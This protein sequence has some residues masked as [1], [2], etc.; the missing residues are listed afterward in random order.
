MCWAHKGSDGEGWNLRYIRTR[1]EP[2]VGYEGGEGLGQPMGSWGSWRWLGRTHWGQPAKL[3]PFY[4][5]KGSRVTVS[6]WGGAGVV[7]KCFGG[8]G[9]RSSLI[10]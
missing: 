1:A 6:S 5:Q 10:F 2:K 4:L 9:Y 8:L 7:M 3:Y